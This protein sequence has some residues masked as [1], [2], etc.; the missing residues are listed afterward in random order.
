MLTA[1]FLNFRHNLG[2]VRILA[3]WLGGQVAR[4]PGS[5]V[6][7]NRLQVVRKNYNKINRAEKNP[8]G[9][10]SVNMTQ[11]GSRKRTV[12]CWQRVMTCWETKSRKQKSYSLFPREPLFGQNMSVTAHSIHPERLPVIILLVCMFVNLPSDNSAVFIIQ[13]QSTIR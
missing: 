4:W 5:Q 12:L 7:G 13:V 10:E 9:Q 6:T 3:R 2:P 1:H 8:K 11:E